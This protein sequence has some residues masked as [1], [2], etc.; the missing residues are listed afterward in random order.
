M[1]A[2]SMHLQLKRRDLPFA[3]GARHALP[4]GLVLFDSYHCSRQNTNTGGSPR[5]CSRRCWRRPRPACTP[6]ESGA[7]ALPPPAKSG[8]LCFAGRLLTNEGPMAGLEISP[9]KVGFVIVKAREIAAK[10]AA[11]DDGATSDHDAES[12]LESFSDDATQDAAQGIHSRPQCRRAGEPGRAGLD[13]QGLVR[14]GGARGGARHRAR[15]AEPTAPTTIC[16]ACRCFPTISRKGSTGSAIR[17][18]T[19]R[20]SRFSVLIARSSR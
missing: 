1:T 4:N 15:R 5:R 16:S 18:R 8:M 3:H 10:V 11:W 7:A 6:A 17:S 13:R 20:T 14:A 2:S 9:D 19:P 12:I